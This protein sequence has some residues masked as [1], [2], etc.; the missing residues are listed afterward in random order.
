MLPVIGVFLRSK[1]TM[2]SES[3][4]FLTSEKV[5]SVLTNAS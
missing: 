1:M 3:V 2:T 4:Y 5:V